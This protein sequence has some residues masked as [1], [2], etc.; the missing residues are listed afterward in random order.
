M[1]LDSAMESIKIRDAKPP[2]REAIIAF[3]QTHV[4][5]RVQN[6]ALVRA[7]WPAGELRRTSSTKAAKTFRPVVA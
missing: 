2:D 6:S 7:S 1:A 5:G 4:L 3:Q